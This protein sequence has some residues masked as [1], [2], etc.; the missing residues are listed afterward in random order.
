VN[1]GKKRGGDNFREKEIVGPFIKHSPGRVR[2]WSYDIGVGDTFELVF[3][4]EGKGRKGATG[5]NSRAV[6]G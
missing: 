6:L 4:G 3:G 2:K 5:G 1:S